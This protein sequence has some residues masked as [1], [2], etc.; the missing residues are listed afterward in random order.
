MLSTLDGQYL[1]D[2]PNEM[3]QLIGDDAPNPRYDNCADYT[4]L[5]RNFWEH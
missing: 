2:K 5:M 1:T 4:S 3:G